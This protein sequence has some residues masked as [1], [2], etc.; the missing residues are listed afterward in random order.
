[1]DC[2][3]NLVPSNISFRLIRQQNISGKLVYWIFTD[4]C[5]RNFVIRVDNFLFAT[6]F[7]FSGLLFFWNL[8]CFFGVNVWVWDY[9]D[10]KGL[11]DSRWLA[12]LL[13][14]FWNSIFLS[15]LQTL[16][17][18]FCSVYLLVFRINLEFP[19]NYL[20]NAQLHWRPN[21]RYCPRRLNACYNFMLE[22]SNN[23]IQ[24][25]NCCFGCI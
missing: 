17:N 11:I 14:I 1:M 7:I 9:F 19:V 4:N 16:D 10:V 20:I 15:F 6:F 8:N 25:E 21:L 12:L 13:L 24:E 2:K 18:F 23:R 3:N 22:L 5:K